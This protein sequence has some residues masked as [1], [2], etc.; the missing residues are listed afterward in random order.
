V[1]LVW[2][3]VSKVAP[4][5][6]GTKGVETKTIPT[7]QGPS[8]WHRSIATVCMKWALN[9]RRRGFARAML[10]CRKAVACRLYLDPKTI[11]QW[12]CL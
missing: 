3:E 9:P 6:V 5:E 1:S 7:L 4:S 12:G 8:V 2:C 10:V 11:Q